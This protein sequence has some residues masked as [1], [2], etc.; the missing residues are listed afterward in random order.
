MT[1]R[2]ATAGAELSPVLTLR[3]CKGRAEDAGSCI[4]PKMSSE[5]AKGTGR[6]SVVECLPNM[7]EGLRSISS[8]AQY[9]VLTHQASTAF[10]RWRQDTKFKAILAPKQVWSQS[11]VHESRSQTNPGYLGWGLTLVNKCG[12]HS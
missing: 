9:S 10:G 3:A 11:Q 2:R 4:I 8:T 7:Q 5:M 12:S 1:T 6:G